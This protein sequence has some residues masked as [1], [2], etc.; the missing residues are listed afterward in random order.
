MQEPD[1]TGG[2]FDRPGLHSPGCRAGGLPS[3]IKQIVNMYWMFGG[4]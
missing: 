3:P 2:L 4:L 1:K